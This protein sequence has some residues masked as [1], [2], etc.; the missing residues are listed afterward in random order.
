MSAQRPEIN[1]DKAIY[2]HE[3]RP[4]CSNFTP[5]SILFMF[6]FPSRFLSYHMHML[7]IAVLFP[8]FL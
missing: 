5:L 1:E 7:S 4:T 6:L 2:E 3:I 8:L